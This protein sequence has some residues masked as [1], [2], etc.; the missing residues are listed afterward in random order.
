V[1]RSRWL[2]FVV[3]LVVGSLVIGACGK[4]DSTT[5]T[6]G[7]ETTTSAVTTSAGALPVVKMQALPADPAALPLLIMIEQGLD[8][9]HGFKA[10]LV[11]VDPDAA[12]T[13]LLIGETDV[14]TEQDAIN[15]TLA[16]QEGQNVLLFAPGLQMTTGMVVADSSAYQTPS[17]LIGKKVGHFGVDSGTTSTMAVMLSELFNIDVFT[18]YDLREAGPEVLPELLKSAEVEA[19]FD[20]EPLAMRAVIQ[21][22]GRYIFQPAKAW[23]EHTGGWAPWLT[24]LVAREEW[25]RA[26]QATAIGVRD[27]YLEG[28][29]IL[30]DSNYTMMGEEPYKSY[31]QFASDQ[32]LTDFVAYCADVQC[33][34]TSWTQEDLTQL[35][36]Y[37]DLFAERKILIDAAPQT[38]VAVV[39][40]DFYAG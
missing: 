1:K 7:G 33:F 37:L 24:N 29:Q 36:A 32:E 30:I 17:D 20:Y 27:A 38:P 11:T 19:I 16:Q 2:A 21:T 10:E 12:A 22:P 26:N 39:L 34:T 3:L 6:T 23:R 25:L 9:A 31:L 40:E 28:M 15:A 13:T 18:Q 35:S 8:V 14:A 5:T 4:S